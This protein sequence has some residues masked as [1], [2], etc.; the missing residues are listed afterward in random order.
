MPLP[1]S[2]SAKFEN[3][4]SEVENGLAPWRS[5]FDDEPELFLP[6]GAMGAMGQDDLEI[7]TMLSI[8]QET[9]L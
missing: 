3:E 9:F 8:L 2:W 7:F 6:F 5:L 4:P 1:G